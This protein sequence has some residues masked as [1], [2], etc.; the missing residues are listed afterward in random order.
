MKSAPAETKTGAS[1]VA[2]RLPAKMQRIQKELPGWIGTDAGK[3][4]KA[5]ALMQQLDQHLKA[6]H[7]QEAEKTADAILGLM[8]IPQPT[9]PAEKHDGRRD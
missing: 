8:G 6:K 7:F 5:T 4:K 9:A 3:E 1:T 2:Q